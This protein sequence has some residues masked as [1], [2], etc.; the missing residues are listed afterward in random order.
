MADIEGRAVLEFVCL[1]DGDGAG[2]VGLFLGTVTDDDHFIKCGG[3]FGEDDVQPAL[4]G[5]ND[6]LRLIPEGDKFHRR[7]L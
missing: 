7:A 2:Q 1:D 3:L 6:R 5:D 4:S